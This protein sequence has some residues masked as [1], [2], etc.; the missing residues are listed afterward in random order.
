MYYACA[1]WF[2][3]LKIN[4]TVFKIMFIYYKIIDKGIM[5]PYIYYMYNL[6]VHV[7]LYMYIL[8]TLHVSWSDVH[9]LHVINIA[10]TIM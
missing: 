1:W 8:F 10:L 5:Q 3:I 6:R 2:R 4:F 9:V 7:L